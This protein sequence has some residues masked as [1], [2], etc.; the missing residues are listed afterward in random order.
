LQLQK[1]QRVRRGLQ[2]LRFKLEIMN[3]TGSWVVP[4]V[5]T[6]KPLELMGRLKEAMYLEVLVQHH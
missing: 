1:G 4:L 5:Q 6:L 3:V 2:L